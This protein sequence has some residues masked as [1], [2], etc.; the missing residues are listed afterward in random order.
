MKAFLI[1]LG[2]ELKKSI[3]GF[4]SN[5]TNIASLATAILMFIMAMNDTS[6]K[7]E[8][9]PI[10]VAITIAWVM[11]FLSKSVL[12]IVWVLG[13]IVM[14]AYKATKE[15]QNEIATETTREEPEDIR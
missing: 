8:P 12:L 1:T 4:F 5:T 3:V 15:Q 2:I 6:L 10:A 7:S 11:F 14:R 9:H 13:T